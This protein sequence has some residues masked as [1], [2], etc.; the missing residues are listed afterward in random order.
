MTEI[1]QAKRIQADICD[2]ADQILSRLGEQ[3]K[4][5]VWIAV[6]ALATAMCALARADGMPYTKL[7]DALT[8]AIEQQQ[9][10]ANASHH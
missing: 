4:G 1:E 8:I 9:G 5:D 6:A 10:E 3:S 7:Q 2:V